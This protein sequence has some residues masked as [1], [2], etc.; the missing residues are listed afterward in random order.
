MKNVHFNIL[1]VWFLKSIAF[2]SN[3]YACQ[4]SFKSDFLYK[5]ISVRPYIRN[6]LLWSFI[7]ACYN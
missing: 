5:T 1:S 2:L 7:K 6:G 4:Y 3:K